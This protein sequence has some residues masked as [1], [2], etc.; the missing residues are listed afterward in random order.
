MSAVSLFPLRL[1]FAALFPL[2]FCK[3]S[4]SFQRCRTHPRL[5]LPLTDV[6][7]LS[8][9]WNLFFW[10]YSKSYSQCIIQNLTVN[11]L[12]NLFHFTYVSYCCPVVTELLMNSLNVKFKCS[13]LAFPRP[14][15]RLPLQS[16]FF[17]CF[18][19]DNSIPLLICWSHFSLNIC[20]S[21][22]DRCFNCLVF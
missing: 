2:L 8:H 20:H 4:V 7:H 6:F 12:S 19:L 15:W 21:I 22:L 13:L 11:A 10:E 18:W 17:F 16:S 14:K 1:S 5:Y 9:V 3:Q